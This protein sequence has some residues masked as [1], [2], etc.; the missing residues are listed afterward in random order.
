MSTHRKTVNVSYT[1]RESWVQEQQQV[2]ISASVPNYINP[3]FVDGKSTIFSSIFIQIFIHFP[4]WKSPESYMNSR[5]NSITSAGVG[6]S[7]C[8]ALPAGRWQDLSNE[9]PWRISWGFQ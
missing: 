7:P 9:K 3:L 2:G 5:M 6:F 1:S 4:E 8:T